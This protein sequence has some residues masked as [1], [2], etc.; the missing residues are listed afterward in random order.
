[1]YPW[2]VYQHTR[3]DKSKKGKRDPTMAVV[4]PAVGKASKEKESKKGRRERTKSSSR[5]QGSGARARNSSSCSTTSTTSVSSSASTAD[6]DDYSEFDSLSADSS[7]YGGPFGYPHTT[8]SSV[9]E[10]EMADFADFEMGD[11]E[12]SQGQG[13]PQTLSLQSTLATHLRVSRSNLARSRPPPTR[14]RIT[15]D[16]GTL[17]CSLHRVSYQEEVLSVLSS[18]RTVSQPVRTP[19]LPCMHSR[20]TS[21]NNCR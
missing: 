6:S 5:V 16:T 8:C 12:C 18:H 10:V 17:T 20:I 11:A 9:R 4:P 19:P 1:M 13:Q 15:T 7:L 14:T 3:P 2:Y 21:P